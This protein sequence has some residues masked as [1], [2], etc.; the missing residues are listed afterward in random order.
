MRTLLTSIDSSIL[1]PQRNSGNRGVRPSRWKAAVSRIQR[2]LPIRIFRPAAASVLE[3]GEPAQQKPAIT[4]AQAARL[5]RIRIELGS[6]SDKV[7]QL[8]KEMARFLSF[9]PRR[10]KQ[11]INQFRL[12]AYL[13][14]ETGVFDDVEGVSLVDRWTLEKLAKFIVLGMLWPNLVADLRRSNFLLAIFTIDRRREKRRSQQ[15]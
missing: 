15:I 8:T 7:R 2:R 3:V 14:Y 13:A 9:N 11:F 12:R 10:I 6:D 4:P 1:F 5:E